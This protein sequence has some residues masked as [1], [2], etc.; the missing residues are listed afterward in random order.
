MSDRDIKDIVAGATLTAVGLFA[1]VYALL[2]M[3]PGTLARMG[4][5]LFPASLGIVLAFF[6]A[7]VLGSAWLRRGEFKFPEVRMRPFFAILAGVVGFALTVDRLGIVPAVFILTFV[8]RLSEEKF[9]FIR[10]LVLASFLSVLAVLI[11]IA[12]LNLPLHVFVW[13]F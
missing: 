11:F 3:S 10:P 9:E 1:F 6:G 4:P 5:G 8:S 12:G 13:P 7:V 2:T